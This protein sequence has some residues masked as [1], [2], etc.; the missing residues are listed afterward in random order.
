MVGVIR[1]GEG[2]ASVTNYGMFDPLQLGTGYTYGVDSSI[3][4]AYLHSGST[5]SRLLDLPETLE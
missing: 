2:R 4:I 3:D 5:L 1:V